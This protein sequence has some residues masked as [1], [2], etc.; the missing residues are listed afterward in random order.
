M[1]PRDIAVALAAVGVILALAG[2]FVPAAR[3]ALDSLSI[4][5]IAAAVAVEAAS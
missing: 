1:S 4:A 2:T 3:G 5:A